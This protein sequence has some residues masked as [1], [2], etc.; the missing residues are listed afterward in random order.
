MD[1]V[2]LIEKM[3]AAC[4]PECQCDALYWMPVDFEVPENIE[5][6]TFPNSVAYISL[7]NYKNTPYRFYYRPFKDY[8]NTIAVEHSK[9]SVKIK[10]HLEAKQREY[11]IANKIV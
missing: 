9:Y 7:L 4:D 11:Y 10:K 8:S 2:S 6:S 1:L 5:G 3:D